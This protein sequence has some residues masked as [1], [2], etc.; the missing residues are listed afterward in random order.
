MTA[1]A[2]NCVYSTQMNSLINHSAKVLVKNLKPKAEE[3][4][5]IEFRGCVKLSDFDYH[6]DGL[7]S[8]NS[9]TTLA[10][11]AQPPTSCRIAEFF[12]L[13]VIGST[14]FGLLVDSQKDPDSQYI[15]IARRAVEL[16]FNLATI[17]SRECFK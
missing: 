17:I 4:E 7:H 8:Y 1:Y 16:K 3:G 11:Y 14:A 12:T 6:S 9:N 13:D 10:L 15:R 2:V 5:V